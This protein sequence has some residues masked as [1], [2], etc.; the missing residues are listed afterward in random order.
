MCVSN[1]IL[2][3]KN[4][5]TIVKNTVTINLAFYHVTFMQLSATE[6]KQSDGEPRAH[7]NVHAKISMNEQTEN[8]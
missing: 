1:G 8:E 6:K 4:L 3:F 2:N 5:I 7:W